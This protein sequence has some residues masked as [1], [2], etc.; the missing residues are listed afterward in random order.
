[1]SKEFREFVAPLVTFLVVL[2]IFG[3]FLFAII[4]ALG[5]RVHEPQDNYYP[6]TTV[7]TEINEKEDL[8]SVTDNNGYVWQFYGVEDWEEKDICSLLMDN[9]GTEN[10]FDDIIIKAQYGGKFDE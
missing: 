9:N 8:V 7:V 10:I 4:Y 6:L 3:C 5:F 1:M 2:V